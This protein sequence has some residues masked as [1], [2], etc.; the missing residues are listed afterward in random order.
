MIDKILSNN[1]D[2]W[3][4]DIIFPQNFFLINFGTDSMPQK[5]KVLQK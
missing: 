5:L 3:K 2:L 4:R 1:A